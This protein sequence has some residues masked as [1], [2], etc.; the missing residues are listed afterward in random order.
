MSHQTDITRNLE[1]RLREL[2]SDRRIYVSESDM[3]VGIVRI[4][5]PEEFARQLTAILNKE[6]PLSD[7]TYVSRE[8]ED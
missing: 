7:R 6:A 1:D 5:M 8:T 4:D 3:H 2:M